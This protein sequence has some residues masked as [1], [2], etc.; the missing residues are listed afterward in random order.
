[1]SLLTK[2]KLIC[3]KELFPR[4][5]R[6]TSEMLHAGKANAESQQGQR[7]CIKNGGFDENWK[8]PARS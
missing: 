6:E 7:Q 3:I 5:D 2:I 8:L 4:Q 1:M